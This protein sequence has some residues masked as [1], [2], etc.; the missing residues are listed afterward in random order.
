VNESGVK[1]I[2]ALPTGYSCAVAQVFDQITKRAVVIRRADCGLDCYCAFELVTEIG[3][4]KRGHRKPMLHWTPGKWYVDQE[5]D[6]FVLSEDGT[7]IA[8]CYADTHENFGLPGI[9]EFMANAH[10]IAKCPE[11]SMFIELIARM[12]THDEVEDGAN[13]HDRIETLDNLIASARQI[14]GEKRKK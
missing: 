11:M 12:K 3:P 10:L 9:S 5:N 4:V 6:R 8:D 13:E 7:L 14:A 1:A 2:G